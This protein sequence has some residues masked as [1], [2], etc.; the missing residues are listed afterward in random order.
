MQRI[1]VVCG[2]GASSTFLVHWMRKV[3]AARGA[4]VEVRAASVR[5]VAA[6]AADADVVLVGHHLAGD[7]DRLRA[8]VDGEH[9]RLVLLPPVSFDETGAS[10]ALDAAAR[11][12]ESGRHTQPEWET[13]HG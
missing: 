2:A 12:F 1:L 7:V 9:A 13:S 3:A 11:D 10:T 5:E 4:D 8:E 6:R